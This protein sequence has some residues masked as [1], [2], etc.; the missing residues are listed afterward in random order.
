MVLEILVKPFAVCTL[1]EIPCA[2]I[3]AGA[4]GLI[5]PISA[6]SLTVN[7]GPI[8]NIMWND[9]SSGFYTNGYVLNITGT[10]VHVHIYH[11]CMYMYMH[12]CTCTHLPCYW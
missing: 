8:L 6:V 7:D 5:N 2:Y 12:A 10:H 3:C 1:Y 11:A 4:S 9:S